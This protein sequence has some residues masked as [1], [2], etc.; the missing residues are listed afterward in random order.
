[1]TDNMFSYPEKLAVTII[2]RFGGL[3]SYAPAERNKLPTFCKLLMIF[4]TVKIKYKL[5]NFP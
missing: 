5:L 3:I 1:M 2:Q 4:E